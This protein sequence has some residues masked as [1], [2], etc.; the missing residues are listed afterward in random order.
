MDEDDDG[1]VEDGVAVVECWS[2][3]LSVGW[4]SFPMVIVGKFLMP[5]YGGGV[6]GGYTL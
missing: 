2:S 6:G 5:G 3:L 1:P 4:R